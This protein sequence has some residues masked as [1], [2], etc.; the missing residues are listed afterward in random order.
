LANA[1]GCSQ[2]FTL[3]DPRRRYQILLAAAMSVYG[4]TGRLTREQHEAGSSYSVAGEPSSA[5]IAAHLGLE[6]DLT[7]KNVPFFKHR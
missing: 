3:S 4:A 5:D 2:Q 1:S 6:H 7:M